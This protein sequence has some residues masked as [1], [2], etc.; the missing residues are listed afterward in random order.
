MVHL[1]ATRA[2]AVTLVSAGIVVVAFAIGSTVIP[3]MDAGSA[4][5]ADLSS[6]SRL[7]GLEVEERTGVEPDPGILALV[8]GGPAAVERVRARIDRD[9]AV[10]RTGVDGNGVVLVFLRARGGDASKDAAERLTEAFAGDE[11]VRLG[12]GAIASRQVTEAIQEDLKRAELIA[13]PL[14]FLLSFW[15]FRGLVAAF[16]PPLVGAGAIALTFLGL[17]LA[18][19]VH[20]LSVFAL[21][22]VTG[23][24]FGLAIDYSLFI[25]SRWREEAAIHGHG[26][27]ALAATMRSAGRTV[28]FSAVTVAASMGCL[29][30]FPQQ[31]LYSMGL[32]GVLVALAAGLVAL[33]PLPAFL[34]WLGPRIDSLRSA[35]AAAGALGRPLGPSCRLGDA[36]AGE[37]RRDL[38]D[39]PHRPCAPGARC[40]L[41]RGRRDGASLVGE[42]AAGRRGARPGRHPG[43]LRADHGD[44]GRRTS[45]RRHGAP[46]GGAG[47]RRGAA[48]P[49]DRGGPLAARSAAAS[50]KGSPT[51]RS[52]S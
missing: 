21:N 35:P 30:V 45:R 29:L 51:G 38:R 48:C 52:N 20:S 6:E 49:G 44:H 28:F 40:Q 15:V 39:L 26:P 17:R 24:G 41:R 36:P 18:I 27:E 7:A 32:G 31:F 42:R 50:R 13:F 3:R 12:G 37:D 10:A 23:L 46:R 25:V 4:Q 16:L 19:E 11:Q 34:Y 47:G 8:T 9:P 22:L 2:R 43:K 5:F 14:V 1:I 33:V